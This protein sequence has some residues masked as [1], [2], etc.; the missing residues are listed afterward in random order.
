MQPLKFI[1]SPRAMITQSFKMTS[2]LIIALGIS[3]FF[4]F[5]FRNDDSIIIILEHYCSLIHL[6]INNQ[7]EFGYFIWIFSWICFNDL[8][9]TDYFQSCI[10]TIFVIINHCY[11]NI[12]AFIRLC[13]IVDGDGAVIIIVFFLLCSLGFFRL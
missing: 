3:W 10:G 13:N 4:F 12:T 8:I 5:K 1:D 6:Q 11:T 9:F 7:N 2:Q